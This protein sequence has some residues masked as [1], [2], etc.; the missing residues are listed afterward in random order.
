MRRVGEVCRAQVIE[1]QRG[2]VPGALVEVA[3]LLIF[4][5]PISAELALVPLHGIADETELPVRKGDDIERRHGF[6]I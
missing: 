5:H 2:E 3:D 6:Q 1:D 4:G